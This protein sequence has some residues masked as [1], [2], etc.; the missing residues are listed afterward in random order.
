MLD[1][2]I[3]CLDLSPQTPERK[4]SDFCAVGLWSDISA[5]LLDLPSLEVITIEKLNGG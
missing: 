3:A 2:E 5:R 1:H 4:K